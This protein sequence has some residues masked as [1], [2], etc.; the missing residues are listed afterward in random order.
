MG[1]LF[2]VYS[3]EQS[4]SHLQRS[5]QFFVRACHPVFSCHCLFPTT[6]TQ[7]SVASTTCTQ[8]SVAGTTCTQSSATDHYL[9]LLMII[10]FDLYEDY[11]STFFNTRFY[12]LQILSTIINWFPIKLKHKITN[13]ALLHCK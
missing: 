9:F 11:C 13:Q 10:Y 4:R 8:Y 3:S 12:C 2:M 6:S 5:D 7:Y 1:A